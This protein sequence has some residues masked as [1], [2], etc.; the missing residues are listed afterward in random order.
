MTSAGSTSLPVCLVANL[1]GDKNSNELVSDVLFKGVRVEAVVESK[2]N[3]FIWHV[4]NKYYTCE[5]RIRA[6]TASNESEGDDDPDAVLMYA[7]GNV[8]WDADAE[9]I[10]SF[11]NLSSPPN[12][13][14]QL[15]VVD[16]FKGD[17][18][19]LAAQTWAV[20]EGEKTAKNCARDFLI[21]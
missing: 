10:K 3:D 19:R 21:F 20:D 15:L 18:D 9:K 7:G 6:V 11:L 13:Q 14:V 12:C 17:E 5:V 16:G 1:A 2:G 4:D 8:N